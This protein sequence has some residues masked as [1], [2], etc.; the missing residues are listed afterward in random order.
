MRKHFS[1]GYKLLSRSVK[2]FKEDDPIRLAGTTAY[3]TIF[4][5]APVI[6]IIISVT[7]FLLGEENIRQKVF[8]ESEKLIGNQG[9][10]YIKSL[11]TN[12]QSVEK[13]I[14]GT[15]VGIVIFLITSTTV[16]VMIQRSINYIWR[17]KA[18]P[19]NDI[20]K[21]LRDR[22]LSFGLILSL[23]F[24]LLVSLLVDVGL[25][26]LRDYLERVLPEFTYFLFQGIKF[27]SFLFDRYADFCF[28]L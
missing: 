18:K 14:I 8:Q 21:T 15:I 2:R 12:Y 22:L 10:E 3:F 20:L 24:I 28:D 7:G 6:I 17:I 25:S 23:G 16:F 27:Y 11:I 26:I 4:A 19:K 5:L 13:S 1:T 9:T